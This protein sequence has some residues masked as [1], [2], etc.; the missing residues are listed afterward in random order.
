MVTNGRSAC[1]LAIA[2]VLVAE[3]AGARQSCNIPASP[4][5][6]GFEPD[7]VFVSHPQ[8]IDHLYAL[9]V[10]VGDIDR[11]GDLDF[12]VGGIVSSDVT[13]AT[14]APVIIYYMENNDIVYVEEVDDYVYPVDNKKHYIHTTF[15]YGVD[16]G[17][18]NEDGWID[19]VV[20]RRNKAFDAFGNALEH[21]TVWIND[22]T[23]A[24]YFDSIAVPL[25]EPYDLVYL[26]SASGSANIDTQDTFGVELAYLDD[27]QPGQPQHLDIVAHGPFGIR[28][29]IGNGDGTFSQTTPPLT[30]PST[31]PGVYRNVEF[32]D[33]NGDRKIDMVVS[34]AS[35]APG[36]PAQDRVWINTTVM[37][38]MPTFTPLASAI[39]RPAAIGYQ[40]R[41]AADHQQCGVCGDELPGTLD[42]DLGDLNSD[43]LPDL[44]IAC[45]GTRNAAYLND[46]MG[47]FGST[48]T[49]G[50]GNPAWIFE[51][52]TRDWPSDNQSEWGSSEFLFLF[53]IWFAS[54]NGL[55][56]PF[57]TGLSWDEIEFRVDGTLFDF[58]S[59]PWIGDFDLDGTVDVTFANRNDFQEVCRLNTI[60]LGSPSPPEFPYLSNDPALPPPPLVYDHVY[61]G[62]PPSS[63]P[64]GAVAFRPCVGLVGKP[65]DGTSYMKIVDMGF[66]RH[67]V[68]W[69]EANFSNWYA[70]DANTLQEYTHGKADLIFGQPVVIPWACP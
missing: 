53:C 23:G 50:D 34:R 70:T 9:G 60:G 44:V 30:D 33:V 25:P 46:G 35:D 41:V 69:V 49:A 58:S 57:P 8:T 7:Q 66:E 55:P 48:A 26:G 21:D 32:G 39:T 38:G 22:Q 64:L 37:N 13:G 3:T 42:I 31:G 59:Q 19:L 27:V 61:Y 14:K 56:Y 47:N 62:V 20:G 12:V 29:Y 67:I 10:E 15:S 4:T 28:I 17:D 63:G 16:L 68:D 40:W 65:N 54:D 45:P 18:V 6:D 11:D 2:L 5:S 24:E 52:P 36:N 1:L 51:T 43:G